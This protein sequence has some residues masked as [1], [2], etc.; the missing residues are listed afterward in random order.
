M[1]HHGGGGFVLHY[2]GGVGNLTQYVSLHQVCVKH[3]RN[4][5]TDFYT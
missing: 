5:A 1:L 4:F 3:E 2:G